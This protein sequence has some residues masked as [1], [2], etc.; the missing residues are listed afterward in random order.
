AFRESGETREHAGTSCSGGRYS[1]PRA[2][3]G[4]ASMGGAMELSGALSPAELHE[5]SARDHAALQRP[6][7]L[8][9]RVEPGI[10]PRDHRVEREEAIAVP[11]EVVAEV[12]LGAGGAAER[13]DE[14]ALPGGEEPRL[15]G[16]RA[17]WDADRD[18]GTPSIDAE[19][20][21]AHGAQT[22]VEDGLQ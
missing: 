22:L 19:E 8:V 17:L 12:L 9:D 5:R 2:V 20:A 10:S 15:E 13:A 16:D 14:A 4:A 18:G 6:D 3:D 7:D 21:G 1:M 11:A